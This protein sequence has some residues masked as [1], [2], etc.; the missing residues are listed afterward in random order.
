MYIPVDPVPILTQGPDVTLRNISRQ[1][2]G[3]MFFAAGR[4]TREPFTALATRS[5]YRGTCNCLSLEMANKSTVFWVFGPIG[6]GIEQV[7]TI[8]P[9]LHPTPLKTMKTSLGLS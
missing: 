3:K 7:L 2:A 5:I 9:F 1:H 4:Y 8:T 6:I